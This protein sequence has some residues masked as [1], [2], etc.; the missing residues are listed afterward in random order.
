[1]APQQLDAFAGEDLGLN[2]KGRTAAGQEAADKGTREPGA[3]SEFAR[4]HAR[5]ADKPTSKAAAKAVA[6]YAAKGP[7]PGNCQGR[8]IH[9][10]ASVGH[11][12]VRPTWT[13][14][15]LKNHVRRYAWQRLTDLE[16][17]GYIRDT[18]LTRAS[19]RG[20]GMIVYALT[21]KARSWI[22]AH[23]LA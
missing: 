21:D 20:H 11:P 19:D 6:P 7:T 1:M 5:T 23:P 10:M 22:A 12:D 18:G 13:S 8:I 16:S 14:D 17:L 3:E 4:T 15:E 2:P 9:A